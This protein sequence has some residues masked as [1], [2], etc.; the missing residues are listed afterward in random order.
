MIRY[1]VC[2]VLVRSKRM[3]GVERVQGAEFKIET[4]PTTSKSNPELFKCGSIRRPRG[5]VTN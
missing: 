1:R 5:G 3:H 2:S 4:S